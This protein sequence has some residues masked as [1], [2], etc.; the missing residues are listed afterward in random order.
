MDEIYRLIRERARQLVAG[1][2]EPD[3][4]RD[5]VSEAKE[6]RIFLKTDPVVVKIFTFVSGKVENNFGHGI[7]HALK[8][9]QDAGSLAIIESRKMGL[10]TETSRRNLL[11]AQCAGLLHDIK[12]NHKDHALKSAEF[13]NDF[14]KGYPFSKEEIGIIVNAIK[15]HEA[16]RE[17]EEW[18]DFSLISDCLYDADKFRWGPDNFTHTV[19]EIVSSANIPLSLF[20]ANYHRGINCIVRIRDTFRSETGKKY[21]PGFIDIGISVGEKLYEIIKSEFAPAK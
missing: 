7:Y 2:P 6:S 12:R 9:A 14:L 20:L 11:M 3:Y 1:F 15:N 17:V 5:H 13:T 21:G 8:V 19:W 16:F 10:D 4:Y 18:E